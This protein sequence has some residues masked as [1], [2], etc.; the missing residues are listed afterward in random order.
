GTFF[1]RETIKPRLPVT[2]NDEDGQE[3]HRWLMQPP[4]VEEDTRVIQQQFVRIRPACDLP[5]LG[6]GC[7]RLKELRHGPSP[8]P[9]EPYDPVALQSRA[10][11]FTPTKAPGRFAEDSQRRIKVHGDRTAVVE[12]RLKIL[13]YPVWQVRYRHA[14]RPYEIAVDGVTGS[15]LAA[16]SPVEIRRAAALVVAAVAVAALCF[17]RPARLL[18]RAG[19]DGGGASALVVGTLGT[20]L[21]LTVGGAIALFLAWVSWTTFRRGGEMRLDGTGAE[22]VPGASVV[23]GGIEGICTRMAK[24]FLDRWPGSSGRG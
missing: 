24:W 9:L 10:V 17:G 4:T 23:P 19:L 8:V 1:L 18:L 6:V 15:I 16:R 12:Q 11:V 2:E 21:G 20:L 5:E 22:P 7:I 3:F 13:H 14:G